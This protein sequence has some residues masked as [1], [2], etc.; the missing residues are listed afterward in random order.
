MK[1][2]NPVYF[3]TMAFTKK[4][5]QWQKKKR[6]EEQKQEAAGGAATAVSLNDLPEECIAKIVSLTIPT[7]ANRLSCVSTTV[8]SAA[9]MDHV[10]VWSNFLP[11]DY[12]T[13]LSR[14]VET[15]DFPSKK[16]LFSYL[17]QNPIHIDQG[18]KDIQIVTRNKLCGLAYLVFTLQNGFYGV[19]RHLAEVSLVLGGE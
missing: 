8:R 6:G 2:L 11:S 14:S 16:Q 10:H 3:G 7:D 9:A 13:I 15:R 1:L 4:Q 19:D 12:E 18:K 17:S 5:N